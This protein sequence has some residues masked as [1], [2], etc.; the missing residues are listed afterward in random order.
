MNV[1]ESVNAVSVG[2][3]SEAIVFRA[4]FQFDIGQWVVGIIGRGKHR[5]IRPAKYA[6]YGSDAIAIAHGAELGKQGAAFGNDAG[7]VTDSGEQA[8][9][10]GLV[11]EDDILLAIFE[12]EG[13]VAVVA[14][15]ENVGFDSVGTGEMF[16]DSKVISKHGR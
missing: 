11:G 8:A 12:T 2:A 7:A 6:K 5:G 14:A 16:I 10:F 13:T 9:V 4:Q 1:V 15:G 3:G